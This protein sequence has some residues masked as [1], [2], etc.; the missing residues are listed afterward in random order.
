MLSVRL[1]KDLEDQLTVLSQNTHRSKSFYVVEALK[2]YLQDQAEYLE[3][4][5]SYE[6][7]LRSGKKGY[8]LE[9]MK[10]RHGVE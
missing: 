6:E 9:E 3:A 8:T 1:S 5:A 10:K 2:A 7:Y 4:V